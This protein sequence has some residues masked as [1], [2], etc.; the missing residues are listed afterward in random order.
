LSRPFHVYDVDA[1]TAARRGELRTRRGIVSTPA[2]MPVGTQAAV[3]TLTPEETTATG[4]EIILANTYHLMLR[5]GLEVVQA[6]GGLHRFMGWSGPILTDSGGFQVFSL[7]QVRKVTE[8]GVQF[9]SHVDGRKLELTPEEAINLQAGFGSDVIMP[10]DELAGFNATDDEQSEA[11]ERTQR[12]LD[13]CVEHFSK[14]NQLPDSERPLIFGIA[15]GGFDPGR[16]T[17]HARRT[18][19]KDVDGYSIGG[20]SVGEPKDVLFD[21]LR[22]SVKGLPA[23]R[24]RYLMG[25]GSP[26]DLWQAVSHGIDMFDCVQPTRVARRGAHYTRFGRVNVTAARFREVFGP[27]DPE[28]DCYACRNFSAAYVHH[29][30][31]SGEML[32]PRLATIHNI[33]FVQVI[34]R[35]I[36]DSIASGNFADCYASFM[37]RYQPVDASVAQDQRAKWAERRAQQ[38]TSTHGPPK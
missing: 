29:L 35:E 15:Q 10:L 11:A 20:L 12:W 13:R 4:S 9:R 32:G 24:P 38:L 5:P 21:M 30:F 6:A 23:D 22:A 8:S 17:E 7:S 33:R 36:R 18:S 34:M 26:E 19:E 27:L 28:C 31:R 16:R 25:V 14:L 37:E 1:T 3:K 2:F